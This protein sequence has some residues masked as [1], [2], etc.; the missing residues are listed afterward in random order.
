MLFRAIYVQRIFSSDIIVFFKG[1]LIP[2][3]FVFILSL[4]LSLTFKL[5]LNNLINLE[6]PIITIILSVFFTAGCTL[7]VLTSEERSII[8]SILHKFKRKF[9]NEN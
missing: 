7:F 5:V 8:F 6:N 1:V 4:I 2:V 3:V 9:G